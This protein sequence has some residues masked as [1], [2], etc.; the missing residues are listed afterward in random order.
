MA[1]TPPAG[2][3]QA[4]YD[5]SQQQAYAAYYGQQQQQGGYDG[6]GGYD[7]N[8][9][10]AYGQQQQQAQAH[11][12]YDHAAY[13]AYYAQQQ[14]AQ[15]QAQTQAQGQQQ[16]LSQGAEVGAAAT[17][18][19]AAAAAAA[20]PAPSDHADAPPIPSD[21][22]PPLPPGSTDHAPGTGGDDADAP[23][24]PPP[25][26]A[27]STSATDLAS[28]SA[29]GAAAA[30]SAASAAVPPATAASMA[31]AASAAAAAAGVPSS[32]AGVAQVAYPYGQPGVYDAMHAQQAQQV[33]GAYDAQAYADYY[34]QQQAYAAYYG[35]Q[36]PPQGYGGQGGQYGGYG[37]QAYGG[38]GGYGQQGAWGAQQQGGVPGPAP[39]PG[40]PSASAAAGAHSYD[41]VPPPAGLGGAP[42]AAKHAFSV[43]PAQFG[44]KHQA[45][46]GGAAVA[47]VPKHPTAYVKVGLP[48]ATATTPAPA[49]PAPTATTTTTAT[50]TAPKAV[51]R[52]YPAAFQSWVERAFARCR[53]N[54]D[55]QAMTGLLTTKVKDVERSGRMWLMDWDREPM[56]P[57][58][59]P[60]ASAGVPPGLAPSV[61]S[62]RSQQQGGAKRSRWADAEDHD[63]DDSDD[64]APPSTRGGR[65]SR[66]GRTGGR[67]EVDLA[68]RGRGALKGNK[69]QQQQ[70]LQ[71]AEAMAEA[72]A[73]RQRISG[74][75]PA[76]LS[77]LND[78]AG[79][80]GDGRA[81]GGLQSWQRLGPGT[82]R[83]GGHGAGARGGRVGGWADHGDDNGDGCDASSSM[84]KVVGYATQLEKSYFRLTA[85]PDPSSVRPEP[86]LRSALSRLN[87]MLASLNPPNWIYACDQYKGMRQDCTV[88]HLRNAT[89]VQVYEAHARAAL[90]YGDIAEFNQCQTQLYV[91]YGESTPGAV[92]EFTA[93]KILYETV[94]QHHPGLGRALLHTIRTAF[95]RPDVATSPEVAHAMAV[96]RAVMT[97]DHSSFFRLYAVAPHLARALMDL[98]AE[99]GGE[100]CIVVVEVC[101]VV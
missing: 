58:G 30:A 77:K 40:Q 90:E 52:K 3:H 1:Y 73:E 19:A 36:L 86:V 79:R 99:K 97:S 10:A 93:Y 76:E 38:Q 43:K 41:A 61:P 64:E 5:Q 56:P 42:G 34:A 54:E 50:A 18:A 44:K 94:H 27:S 95:S 29:S 25:P 53:G 35:Q 68:G 65:H 70:Q 84:Q 60:P 88:Q 100:A 59:Q 82:A 31:A 23:P 33:Q 81:L 20:P 71:R 4:A 13:A 49:A 8:T 11:A 98:S 51:P 17:A 37:Q 67:H 14:A 69:K 91:M 83:R 24:P 92:A 26:A 32:V 66:G 89:A 87:A 101:S 46:G 85:A 2:G 48:A 74:L 47:A 78:R 75:T 9:Y 45:A 80:F 6:A 62:Q 57:V 22:P 7:A 55:R 12:A 72:N 96:R 39:P 15:A 63:Q 21:D 16:S 28:V